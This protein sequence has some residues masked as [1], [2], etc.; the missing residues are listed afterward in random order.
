MLE[1]CPKRQAGKG[2]ANFLVLRYNVRNQVVKVRSVCGANKKGSNRTSTTRKG[3]RNPIYMV[4]LYVT[5]RNM[6]EA[7]GIAQ[8][9]IRDKAAGWVNISPVNSMYRE[10]DEVKERDGAALIVKTIES[11]VQDVEDIVRAA[12]KNRIHCV[13]SFTLY[14]L[15]REYKDWLIGSLA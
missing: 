13:A 6:E 12:H 9:L 14:R 5:T 1:C 4:F 10:G 11:K 2:F 7:K 8:T 15:N 3:R